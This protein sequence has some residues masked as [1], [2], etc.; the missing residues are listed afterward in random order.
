[1]RTQPD[2]RVHLGA[3]GP[4]EQCPQDAE[5]E[6]DWEDGRDN[7]AQVVIGCDT[8]QRVEIIQRK[9][10]DDAKGDRGE[11]RS[12]GAPLERALARLLVTRLGPG[13]PLPIGL[14]DRALPTAARVR[15]RPR[16]RASRVFRT[17]ITLDGRCGFSTATSISSRRR[18]TLRRTYSPDGY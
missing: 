6:H 15:A 4:E 10:D 1:V 3:V 9:S 17:M 5:Q 13:M 14:L 2:R 8:E 11:A 18:S 12:D 7:P 16:R